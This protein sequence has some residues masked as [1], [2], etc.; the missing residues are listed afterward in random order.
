MSD[1]K[2]KITR[3]DFLCGAASTMAGVSMLN[4]EVLSQQTNAPLIKALDDP[5]ITHGKVTFKSGAGTIDGYLSR[6]KAKGRYPI[7]IVV[8]GNLISEEYIRN[9]TAI[10]AQGGFVGLAPNIFSLQTDSMSADEKRKVFINQI[11]DEHV[12]RDVQAGIDYLKKQS[13]AKRNRI[14]ITGFCFGGRIALMFAAKS[15]EIDAVVPFYGNLRLPPEFNRPVNPFDIVSDIKAPVQ[16]HY[17]LTDT[18]IPQSDVKK[19]FEILQAQGTRAELYNY[20]AEHGFFAYTRPTYHAE[21]ARVAQNRMLEF[22][23]QHLK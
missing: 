5:G 22:F 2:E 10:L 13:F 11:T 21:A 17:A 15:E 9:T 19:F 8:A 6:P 23:R 16:G 1:G 4:S 18:G 3:R 20:E 12:F 7:V 14:G